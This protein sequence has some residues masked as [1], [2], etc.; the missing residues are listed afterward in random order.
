[1]LH[2]PYESPIF[3]RWFTAFFWLLIVFYLWTTFC[4]IANFA[5]RDPVYDQFRL[6]GF[7][8][9]LP[10]PDNILQLENGH[11]P[12][13]PA[14][15]RLLE[16]HLFD[17]SQ[18]L[19]T[20]TGIGLAALTC[21]LIVGSIL[22]Q[23]YPRPLCA[24][25]ILLTVLGVFWLGSAR[26]LTHGNESV[27]TYGVTLAVTLAALAVWCAHTRKRSFFIAMA[28]LACA[29]ATFSFGP[30]LASFVAVIILMLMLRMP[31]RWFLWP[32][33]G[34]LVCFL[35]YFSL[36]GGDGVRNTIAFRPLETLI[37]IMRWLSSP[38]ILAGALFQDPPLHPGAGAASYFPSILR[39]DW[40]GPLPTV[41]G[42]IGAATFCL[43]CLRALFTKDINRVAAIAF[44]LGLFALGTAAIVALG[45]LDYFVQLP[46]QIFDLRYIVWPCFFWLAL[47]LLAIN[48]AARRASSSR[49]HI[50]SIA[51]CLVAIIVVSWI[52]SQRIQAKWAMASF[53]SAATGVAALRSN[54]N[55]PQNNIFDHSNEPGITLL[56]KN[57]LGMFRRPGPDHLGQPVRLMPGNEDNHVTAYLASTGQDSRNGV[58]FAHIRGN[59]LSDPPPDTLLAVIDDHDLL[60]GFGDFTSPGK[61][62]GTPWYYLVRLRGFDAY[63]GHYDSGKTYRIIA[64]QPGALPSDNKGHV[65][66]TITV[67]SP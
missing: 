56:R 46:G 3:T 64:L 40:R 24:A 14:L 29:A 10:F 12:I 22:K 61:G 31:W 8:L 57:R 42:F 25:G 38:L 66:A 48:G 30:G 34:L 50:S 33:V 19:Q 63:I 58:T 47:G 53:Y 2:R 52:P 1:M 6:Y 7:Y 36:P 27:H 54:V 9:S 23:N 44:M 41:V 20:I 4:V 32:A 17:A 60:V 43:L 51:T 26:M 59:F 45:R 13:L 55:D 62:R 28:T 15:V 21:L 16:I 49:S 37:V 67:P 65:L 35:A 39:F 11:R 18:T 5:L